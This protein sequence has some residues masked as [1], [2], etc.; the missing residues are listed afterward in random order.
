MGHSHDFVNS[1][2]E[3]SLYDQPPSP[4]LPSFQ[5]LILFIEGGCWHLDGPVSGRHFAA[6]AGAQVHF[7]GSWASSGG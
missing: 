4:S 7:P 5:P 6:G 1:C 3:V 2:I